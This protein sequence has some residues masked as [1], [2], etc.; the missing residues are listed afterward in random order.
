MQSRAVFYL[1]T[2]VSAS[3]RTYRQPR[4]SG[5]SIPRYDDN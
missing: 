4:S 1:A 3:N 2:L 5:L